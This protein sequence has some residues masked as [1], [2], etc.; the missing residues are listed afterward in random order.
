MQDCTFATYYSYI[1]TTH[2]YLILWYAYSPVVPVPHAYRSTEEVP[3][4]HQRPAAGA[5]RDWRRQMSEGKAR[6]GIP[7][8]KVCLPYR[9]VLP[10]SLVE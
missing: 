7:E 6:Q 5:G 4:R 10:G 2:I 9:T 1:P 8:P 3:Q